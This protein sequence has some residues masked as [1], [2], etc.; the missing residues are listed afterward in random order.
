MPG[1]GV[2]SVPSGQWRDIFA[3]LYADDAV[4]LATALR[5][6]TLPTILRLTAD[7]KN[8]RE[9]YEHHV[10]WDAPTATGPVSR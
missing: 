2:E 8:A 4:I 1:G 5:D 6:L 9:V 10:D 3:D 7:T